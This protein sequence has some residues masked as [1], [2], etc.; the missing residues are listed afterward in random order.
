MRPDNL[1]R[2]RC[3]GFTLSSKYERDPSKEQN[4]AQLLSY[5][6]ERAKWLEPH[7]KTVTMMVDEVHEK[8]YFD[9]KGDSIAG[10]SAHL[11]EPATTCHVFMIQSLL[12]SNKDVHILP[13]SRLSAETLHE[14][15]KGIILKMEKI[16]LMVVA[17]ITDNNGINLFSVL[18]LFLVYCCY[19]YLSVVSGIISVCEALAAL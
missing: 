9:F 5:I 16:G 14:F 13:V 7:E 6:R 2:T 11:S 19:L 17:V 4:E 8:P 1:W 18:M 15:T 12:S 10:S 3:C